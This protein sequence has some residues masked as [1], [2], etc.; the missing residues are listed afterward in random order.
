MERETSRILQGREAARVP[1][2]M[3]VEKLTGDDGDEQMALG[4][5]WRRWRQA[6]LPEPTGSPDGGSSRT[7]VDLPA[8]RLGVGTRP[9]KLMR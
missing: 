4:A 7:A 6:P 8:E 5:S 9:E 3:P 2:S 1:L